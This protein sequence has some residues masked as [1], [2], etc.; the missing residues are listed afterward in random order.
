MYPKPGGGC[1][2]AIVAIA[3]RQGG[4]DPSGLLRL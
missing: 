3:V 1:S 4:K 2:G